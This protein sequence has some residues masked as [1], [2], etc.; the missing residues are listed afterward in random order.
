MS[1]AFLLVHPQIR[2]VVCLQ[3]KKEGV[4]SGETPSQWEEQRSDLRVVAFD[5][6]ATAAIARLRIARAVA[7]RTIG[8]GAATIIRAAHFAARLG[9]RRLAAIETLRTGSAIGAGTA[10][11]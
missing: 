10:A 1:L 4:S 2:D 11:I 6:A 3:K 7:I 5:G 9:A 8:A